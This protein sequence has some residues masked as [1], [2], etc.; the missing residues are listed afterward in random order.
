MST[1]E[2][3]TPLEVKE[4]K[5]AAP[6]KK[7]RIASIDAFRGFTVLSM[8]FVIQ[9]AGYA[10]LPFTQ[11]WFGS[12]PVSQF[13][14]AADG[15]GNTT[16]VGL[17]FT[18]LVAPF[19]V[20]IVGMVLPLSK[21]KRGREWWKHVGTRTFLLIAL[22]VL[23]ISLILNLSYWWGILQAIG[24]AY[25]M[26]ASLMLLRPA[27]RWVAV[28]AIAAFHQFM[29]LT[30]PWWLQLGDPAKPFLTITNL[31]GD[32][33]R[34][35][36]VHCT[37]WA[38]ISYGL[39]TVIGTLL[40]EAVLSRSHRK[41]II[42]ALSMGAVLCI[43]GYLLHLYQWPVFA[44]NKPNVS[45]SYAIFTSG[46]ASFTFLIFYMIMD[47]WQIQSWAKPFIVFGSNALLGYFL[48]PIVR[49]FVFA[50]G[51]KPYLAG[52]SG[53]DGVLFGLIWTALLWVVLLWCNKR[54]IYWKI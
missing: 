52:H 36:T 18:D 43:A 42:Q 15:I 44:M 22:G 47:Y 4:T 41:I 25:F 24:I 40:G 33:L 27:W 8:I 50:L 35:L 10:N 29:S 13:H 21:R 16:G 32:A 17:T 6:A 46:V 37:P 30:F 31:A 51:F 23:Y 19:F 3:T 12:T 11:S 9:V 34:P 5:A 14:H 54:N 26:G 1:L 2:A 48:Q 39:I 45:A 38:S 7:P 20:F 53:W 28:I 49:I